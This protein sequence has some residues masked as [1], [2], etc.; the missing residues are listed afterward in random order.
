MRLTTSWDDGYKLDLK[1]VEL[2][3]QYGIKGTFYVCPRK[4]HSQELLSKEDIQRI[5]NNHEIGAH[6]LRHPKL[7]HLSSIDAKTEIAE[8]KSWV[9][10]ITDK[11]CEMFCYP[12]GFWNDDIKQMVMSAGYKGARTTERL[13]FTVNDPHA[14]PTTLQVTPF[15][16]R[17]A[18]SRIW[19]PIDPYGPLRVRYRKLKKI[20]LKHGEMKNWLSL[21]T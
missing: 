10:Q 3:D 17:K 21:A 20:G 14:M 16:R 6:T 18:W 9:E 8:S 7:T 1:L 15:P 5:S 13:E 12:Y 4:Q 11:P 19:H 2:L